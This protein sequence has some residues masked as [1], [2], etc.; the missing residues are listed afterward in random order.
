[1]G[2]SRIKSVVPHVANGNTSNVVTMKDGTQMF[3]FDV[4]LEDENSGWVLTR[5]PDRWH[6]GDEVEYNLLSTQWGAKLSLQKPRMNF[7]GG[8][9][10]NGGGGGGA[11]VGQV[12]SWAV[13]CAVHALGECKLEKEAYWQLVKAHAKSALE[14][15]LQVKEHV[16]L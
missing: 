16:T 3:K 6:V 7:N 12:A 1:M 5:T 9:G 8:G 15:R 2:I 13:T 10:N 14:V 11:A 4:E